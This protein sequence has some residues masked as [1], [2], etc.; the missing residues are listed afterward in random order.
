MCACSHTHAHGTD[1]A[2]VC[3]TRPVCGN[4]HRPRLLVIS[5]TL[6]Q[7]TCK[8][9]SAPLLPHGT[10]IN[11]LLFAFFSAVVLMYTRSADSMPT[12]HSPSHTRTVLKKQLLRASRSADHVTHRYR[13]VRTRSC[14]T[15]APHCR[16]TCSRACACAC[17][18]AVWS[19]TWLP[20][21]LS[22]SFEASK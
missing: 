16:R 10:P 21:S 4:A 3:Q 1:C 17:A 19:R 2:F 22:R 14:G 20:G 18:C 15:L 11:L 5:M 6:L 8:Y 13:P 9:F 12:S 7:C